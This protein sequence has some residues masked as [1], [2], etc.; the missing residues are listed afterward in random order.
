MKRGHK[1][2]VISLGGSVIIPD[3]PNFLFLNKFRLALKKHYK[4]YKFVVVCGG[5]SI[6]RKYIAALKEE[7]RSKK[8]LSTAGI[9]ATRMNAMFVMQF[10]GKEANGSLPRDMEEV[11][12]NLAKN[13][14]VICGALRYAPDS[15]SD[16]TAAKLAH[17][18][19]ANFINITN[20]KGLFSENPKTHPKA[21]FIPYESWKKFEKRALA[22]SYHAGQHFVLD[23]QAA[24]IIR[25]HKIPTYII[26]SDT[27]NIG[28]ILKGKKFVGTLICC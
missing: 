16:G 11:K 9:R 26:G 8:E 20:V 23:Q 1:I 21:K 3:K 28:K 2:I 13:S 4:T 5:G 18:L 25:E 6:A 27:R 12:S 10:F 24:V 22:L 17:F 7:H 15:T 19:K 14:V